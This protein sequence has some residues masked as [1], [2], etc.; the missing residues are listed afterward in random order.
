MQTQG[1]L[2]VTTTT[3][4]SLAIAAWALYVAWRTLRATAKQAEV[5]EHTRKLSIRPHVVAFTRQYAHQAEITYLTIA[6]VGFGAAKNV[7]TRIVK[8]V[9]SNSLHGSFPIKEWAPIKRPVSILRINE[10][11]WTILRATERNSLSDLGPEVSVEITYED[12]EGTTYGPEHFT[13]DWF[14]NNGADSARLKRTKSGEVV[15][16]RRLYP[17]EL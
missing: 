9:H 12:I 2:Q 7:R 5:A 6:N 13:L 16:E 4:L 17:E 8:G 11:L 15:E 14:P 1:T 3:L 10:R